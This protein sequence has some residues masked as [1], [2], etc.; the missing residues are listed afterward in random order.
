[1]LPLAVKEKGREQQKSI[2]VEIEEAEYRF[3]CR[4]SW[5]LR[6][7][8]FAQRSS[9]A[10]Q[11]AATGRSK[12]RRR[13]SSEFTDEKIEDHAGLAAQEL[14]AYLSVSKGSTGEEKKKKKETTVSYASPQF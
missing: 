2:S 10:T 9:E 11:H 1:M 12:K 14:H 3:S 6:T 13:E 5:L 7:L 8:G 4:T